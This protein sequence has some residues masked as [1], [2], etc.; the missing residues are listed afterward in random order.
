[1][2]WEAHLLCKAILHKG[3]ITSLNRTI[4]TRPRVQTPQA[5]G[6]SFCLNHHE[7]RFYSIIEVNYMLNLLFRF[8]FVSFLFETVF[9]CVALACP[10]TS[11]IEITELTEILLHLLPKCWD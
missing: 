10:G 3:S 5:V 2:N 9:L 1:M 6:D 11:S 7:R 4:S 8:R